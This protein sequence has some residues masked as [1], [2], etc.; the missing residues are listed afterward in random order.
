[1]GRTDSLE[2]LLARGP[3][4][5]LL[6]FSLAAAYLEEGELERALTHAE[7]AVTLDA[8]YSAAW[9]L[10]AKIQTAQGRASE[11]AATYRRGIDV[12]ERRGDLQAAK[13]M[14]VFLRRLERPREDRG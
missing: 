3:D 7:A 13:E 6:R 1:V 2:A 5:A 14:R 9:K 10:L 12:A 4:G 11:A 8:A